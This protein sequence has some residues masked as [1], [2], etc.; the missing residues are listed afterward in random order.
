MSLKASTW[1]HLLKRPVASLKHRFGTM[2]TKIGHGKYS[3]ISVALKKF[4]SHNELSGISLGT[5]YI[6]LDKATDRIL[7][8]NIRCPIDIPPFQRSTVDGYAIL[9]ND[10]LK[11]TRSHHVVLN[12]IGQVSAGEIS[13]E[14]ISA[15]RAVAIATGAK[16]P[17]GADSVIMIEDVIVEDEGRNIHITNNIDKG[18]NISPRGNDLKKGQ[19]LLKEGTWLAPRIL[20]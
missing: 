2:S 6:S 8:G 9:S 14:R 5:E 19:L 12:V 4:L 1:I 3:P 18:S 17:K 16:I 13:P 15:G 11:A 20:G 7:A 10:T